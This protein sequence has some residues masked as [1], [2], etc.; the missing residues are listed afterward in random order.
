MLEP[1]SNVTLGDDLKEIEQSIPCFLCHDAVVIRHDKNQ[2]PY[3]ICD[4]CGIQAFIRRKSGIRL[5]EKLR[6]DSFFSLV[7][8]QLT[9]ELTLLNSEKK[10]ISSRRGLF[11]LFAPNEE[12]LKAEQAITQKIEI[13]TEKIN[14]L[15]EKG[16][17]DDR[18]V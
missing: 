4:G 5:L 16:N 18:A 8:I 2:K 15:A 14:E 13:I 12:L 9:R 1:P 11:G 6:I 3:F 10:K 7:L 17:T